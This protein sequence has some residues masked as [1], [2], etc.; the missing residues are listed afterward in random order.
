MFLR[1]DDG[2]EWAEGLRINVTR[3]L[4]AI[5][6]GQV[7]TALGLIQMKDQF[8]PV[9]D[10]TEIPEVHMFTVSDLLGEGAALAEFED[11]ALPLELNLTSHL[12][13]YLFDKDDLYFFERD[14]D[15]DWV[16]KTIADA[17]LKGGRTTPASGGDPLYPS[18]DDIA[19][20]LN[21]GE[22][23]FTGDRCANVDGDC[24]DLLNAVFE[25]GFADQEPNQGTDPMDWRSDAL[26]H[27][28]FLDSV[29]PNGT[30]WE[31]AFDHRLD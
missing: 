16:H 1:F 23:Y 24:T 21:L 31:G 8:L 9:D 28:T 22:D 27:A 26:T 29:Y 3:D 14:G 19:A 12:G 20:Y 6:S 15:W 13:N 2:N 4:T 7:F 17:V 5:L 30:D 10:I 25:D 11:L 18:L